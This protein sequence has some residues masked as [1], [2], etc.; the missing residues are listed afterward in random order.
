MSEAY[1]TVTVKV[2]LEQVDGYPASPERDRAMA[3]DW[4]LGE[5][6]GELVGVQIASQPAFFPEDTNPD[7]RIVER[8]LMEVTER[9]R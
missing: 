9:E 1:V 2:N 5:R 6:P 4:W 8:M 7:M 3:I